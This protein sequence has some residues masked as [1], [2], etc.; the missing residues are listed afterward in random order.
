MVLMERA[1]EVRLQECVAAL[2][3]WSHTHNVHP[4]HFRETAEDLVRENGRVNRGHVIRGGKRRGRWWGGK[5]WWPQ[6]PKELC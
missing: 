4:P 2:E 6:D 3:R 1:V 5:R